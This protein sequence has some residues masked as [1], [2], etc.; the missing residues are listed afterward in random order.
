[1]KKQDF[2]IN[3]EKQSCNEATAKL[4]Q[5]FVQE[6]VRKIELLLLFSQMGKITNQRQGPTWCLDFLFA[7]YTM[8]LLFIFSCWCFLNDH[9]KSSVKWLFNLYNSLQ[10]CHVIHIML[11]FFPVFY[12][13]SMWEIRKQIVIRPSSCHQVHVP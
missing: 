3:A 10:I 9:F 12:F 5:I 1:M 11:V 2:K 13:Q 4:Y 6:K 8:N 7:T